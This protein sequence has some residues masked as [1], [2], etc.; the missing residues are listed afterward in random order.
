MPM[1][2]RLSKCRCSTT[3]LGKGL[4]RA[5]GKR[6]ERGDILLFAIKSTSAS[7]R[8]SVEKENVPFFF[9]FFPLFL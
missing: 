5:R 1:G 9:F 4:A 6:G 2:T 3:L 8:R 7:S